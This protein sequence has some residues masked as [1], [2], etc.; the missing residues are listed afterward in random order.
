MRQ[1]IRQ[2]DRQNRPVQYEPNGSPSEAS[3]FF[4]PMYPCAAQ[5]SE[6]SK[7]VADPTE[8]RPIISC[9]YRCEFVR[10]IVCMGL[11]WQWTDLPAST[12]MCMCHSHA[13]GNSNG[14]LHEYHL[15]LIPCA[16]RQD[17]GRAGVYHTN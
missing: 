6:L 5:Y 12:M 4:C 13:M 7:A 17:S 15:R 2:H 10:C 3:D 8:R 9:E 1:W 11:T 16:I 14:N